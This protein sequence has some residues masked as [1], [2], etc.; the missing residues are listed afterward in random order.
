MSSLLYGILVYDISYKLC[1]TYRE[2]D[3]CSLETQCK[4]IFHNSNRIAGGKKN[5]TPKNLLA[6]P[7]PSEILRE[8]RIHGVALRNSVHNTWHD[9]IW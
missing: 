4:I 1:N 8:A 5:S 2:H 3:V 7:T 9:R 6:A